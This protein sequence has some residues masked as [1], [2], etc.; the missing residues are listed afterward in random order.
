MCWPIRSPLIH[1]GAGKGECARQ[2]LESRFG[3][4][5]SKW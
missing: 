1:L 2:V 3:L 4:F 5:V